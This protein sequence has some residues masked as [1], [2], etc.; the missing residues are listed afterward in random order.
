MFR[1]LFIPIILFSTSIGF[2]Q[3]GTGQWQ[4]HIPARKAIDLAVGD[5]IILTA[6]ESGLVEYDTKENENRVLNRLNALS[7]TKI[8]ALVFEPTTKRFFI[9]YETGNIDIY[10]NGT[11]RNFPDIFISKV[12]G[13]KKIIHFSCH[14]GLIYATTSIGLV[15]IDAQRTEVKETYFPPN[16]NDAPNSTYVHNDSIFILSQTSLFKGALKNPLLTRPEQWSKVNRVFQPTNGNFAKL[17]SYKD[18]LYVLYKSTNFGSDSVYVL[19]NQGLRRK[20]GAF[21][22][23]E[24]VDFDVLS[25]QQIVVYFN[26]GLIIFD[27]NEKTVHAFT[28]YFPSFKSAPRRIIRT[29]SA[30][31][32]ADN[33]QGLVR[34]QLDNGYNFILQEGPLKNSF[35]RINGTEK[36]FFVTGGT[37]DRVLFQYKKDGAMRYNDGVW[38]QL[39]MNNQKLWNTG[40]VWDISVAA[41]NPSN[42][43]EAALGSYSIDALSIVKND[44]VSKIYNAS[45]SPLEP[46]TLGNGNVCVSDVEYDDDGNLWVLNGYSTEPLKCLKADGTWKTYNTGGQTTAKFT[47]DLV[48]DQQNNKWFGVTG[49]GLV[50]V[51][52]A[53][54]YVVLNATDGTGNLPSL[55]VTTLAVDFDNNIWIGTEEGFSVLYNSASAIENGTGNSS[56]ILIEYEGNTENLLGSTLITDIE[57]DGGNRKWIATA[58]TGIFLL[59]AN[60]QEVL[61]NYT[62]ENSP[63]ISD[64][65]LDMWIDQKKGE[66]FVI[67]DLG[68]VS[69]RIDAT[70]ED[71]DYSSINVFPNPVKPGFYGPITI[72]GIR[73]N[74]DVKITDA[75][76]N[77]VYATTSNGGTATWNGYLLDGSP[78]PS[79]MYF[80][81]TASNEVKA[82]KVAQVVIIR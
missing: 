48:I 9:G 43:N 31:Y 47:T 3:I 37:I 14:N 34:Y 32:I 4:M 51:D 62:Q 29:E 56:R 80:I 52:T 54:N 42:V 60:G 57:I 74:S 28:T 75:G 19:S 13:D 10:S 22:S 70:E 15:V 23:M 38:T 6:L 44:T 36:T 58:S 8:S 24:I 18:E 20:I 5:N 25:D 1:F 21:F 77:L 2:A 63:L 12:E 73:F 41:V 68:M 64:N 49:G 16:L 7:D 69:L 50:G 17:R 82:K 59:S 35:Y 53:G 45:N 76:G 65:I 61:A 71:P 81:W 79:G 66:L 11:I 40:K 78:A 39:D 55:N 72:Q 27:Q 26:E 33:Q 30:Y 67:T 46:S